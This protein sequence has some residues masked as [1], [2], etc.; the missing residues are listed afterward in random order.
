MKLKRHSRK[1]GPSRES[2]AGQALQ[3][4]VI[5]ALIGLFAGE[6]HCGQGQCDVHHAL[7]LGHTLSLEVLHLHRVC[8]DHHLRR[9]KNGETQEARNEAANQLGLAAICFSLFFLF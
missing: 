4:P 6:Q 3:L 5:Y 1:V 9:V 8:R 7:A 2:V